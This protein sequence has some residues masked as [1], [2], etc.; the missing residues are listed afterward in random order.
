[1]TAGSFQAWWIFQH[2]FIGVLQSAES[3]L[4]SLSEHFKRVRTAWILRFARPIPLAHLV[5]PAK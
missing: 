5:M 2:Q 1:M 4:E 3:L